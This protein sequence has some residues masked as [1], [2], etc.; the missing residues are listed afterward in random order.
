MQNWKQ[1]YLRRRYHGQ[2]WNFST[3]PSRT[4]PTMTYSVT[5]PMAKSM[6]IDREATRSREPRQYLVEKEDWTIHELVKSDTMIRGRD[7]GEYLQPTIHTISIQS[8]PES[9]ICRSILVQILGFC[10]HVWYRFS[11]KTWCHG[12][13]L[14]CH[15]NFGI[16]N[17]SF[18]S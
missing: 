14:P 1:R 3:I 10:Y 18:G 5:W 17:A 4:S 7:F 11:P 6:F 8:L 16:W 12:T 9:N 13:I 15:F 2:Y